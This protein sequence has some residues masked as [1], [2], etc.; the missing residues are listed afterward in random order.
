MLQE[1]VY[2]RLSTDATVSGLV[3]TRIYPVLAPEGVALPYI[4]YQRIAVDHV[5]SVA[6]SSGLANAL[7]QVDCW[8]ASYAG[9]N[10]LGEAV[11]LRM[12]GFRGTVG[13]QDIQAVLLSSDRDAPEDPVRIERGGVHGDEVGI[14]GVQFD[15]DIWYCEAQPA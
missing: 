15:F 4:T 3:G 6:G 2:T 1:A 7:V 10:A 8:A 11:R 12:Q 13:S 14:H 5:E 9:A